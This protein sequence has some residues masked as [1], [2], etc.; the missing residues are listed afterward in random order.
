MT[1]FSIGLTFKTVTISFI[2]T[3]KSVETRRMVG[4]PKS[5]ETGIDAV[6]KVLPKG[7]PRNSLTILAGDLGTGKSVLMEQLLYSM[8]K[9]EKEPC[10]YMNFEG[11]PIALQQ[12]MESFGW[13]IDRY[14]D[15]GQLRF[16]D[17]F[18]FRMEPTE[19][20]KYSH[21]VKDPKDLHS[22]TSALF[23]MMEE[24]KMMGRGAVFVDSLTEMFTLVQE[25]RPLVFHML[26]GVKSWRA[27]GPKERLVPFFCS[28]HT[29]LR[30]YADLDDLLFYVVDGIVDVR[31]NPGFADRGLLVKQFRIRK[32]KGAP[33]ETHWV[34][35]QVTA[36]GIVEVPL[37]VPVLTSDKPRT[38][39]KK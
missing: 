32:M 31:F 18:S 6:D 14:L 11:P 28:H 29:P 25:E 16:L 36:S 39:K 33:H 8:L 9:V 10:I 24:M 35:F 20:P 23:T 30:A 3:A 5:F 21:F 2:S 7:I 1:Q 4:L 19:T 15:S 37:P 27:K 17:C 13:D 12:D 38:S 26:D 22:V 34:T